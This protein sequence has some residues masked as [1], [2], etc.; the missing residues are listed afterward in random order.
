MG[1][2][3]LPQANK[4]LKPSEYKYNIKAKTGGDVMWV[5]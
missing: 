4:A 3:A 2:T 1:L 5:S